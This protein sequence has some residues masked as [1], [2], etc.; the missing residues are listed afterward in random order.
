MHCQQFIYRYIS[1]E[2]WIMKLIVK[3]GRLGGIRHVPSPVCCISIVMYNTRY[4][5][6]FVVLSL[7]WHGLTVA[8]CKCKMFY[9][10]TWCNNKQY[11]G[12]Q[13]TQCSS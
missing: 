13:Q 2:V 1:R 9:Q 7:V 6:S 8:N 4:H 3:A 5:G 10:R 11:Y 12:N